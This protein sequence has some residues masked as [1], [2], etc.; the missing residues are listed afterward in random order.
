M[1]RLEA[2]R[3]EK[4]R[5]DNIVSS[6]RV[7]RHILVIIIH[8]IF[9][10]ATLITRTSDIFN[11]LRLRSLLNSGGFDISSPVE[12]SE[13]SALFSVSDAL[14][15]EDLERRQMVISGLL[16]GIGDFE[17]VSCR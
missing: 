12:S 5:I 8:L 16:H 10:Q 11:I 13:V 3:A 15:G 1:K 4:A 9:L 17:G 7:R 14:L 2:E 6:D